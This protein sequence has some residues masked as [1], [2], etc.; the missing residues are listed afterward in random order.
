M[1][2]HSEAH[3]V[4]EVLRLSR[5]HCI[6][7]NNSLHVPAESSCS[8]ADTSLRSVLLALPIDEKRQFL[9]FCTGCDRAPVAG[10]AALKLLI[11]VSTVICA[12]LLCE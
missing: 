5:L 6:G 8:V 10:L 4:L 12:L 11:Q 7:S 1:L 2:L 3:I 9:Q